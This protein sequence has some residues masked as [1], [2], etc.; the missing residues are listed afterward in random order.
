MRSPFLTLLRNSAFVVFEFGLGAAERFVDLLLDL[1]PLRLVSLWDTR[2]GCLLGS[3]LV[4]RSFGPAL[5][6]DVK[7]V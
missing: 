4:G 6:D 7:C 3:A 5:P 1:F 2:L